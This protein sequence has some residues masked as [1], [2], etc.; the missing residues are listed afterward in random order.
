MTNLTEWSQIDKTTVKLESIISNRSITALRTMDLIFSKKNTTHES[1]QCRLCKNLFVALKTKLSELKEDGQGSTLCVVCSGLKDDND[2]KASHF[3][4]FAEITKAMVAFEKSNDKEESFAKV[5][6]IV[7][8][9]FECDS[10]KDMYVNYNKFKKQLEHE[11]SD[12]VIELEEKYRKMIDLAFDTAKK[13]GGME[14]VKLVFGTNKDEEYEVQETINMLDASALRAELE[15]YLPKISNIPTSIFSIDSE[16]LEKIKF[17]LLLLKY[18]Q[19]I[20]F[21]FIYHTF[22][23]LAVLSQGKNY[24]LDPFPPDISG[25]PVFPNEKILKTKTMD[26]KLGSIFDC[27]YVSTLRN[28]IAHAKYSVQNG[29]VSKIDNKSWKMNLQQVRDKVNLTN[30]IFSYL[31]SKI[32][33]EQA[34]FYESGMTTLP[35]GD[36]VVVEFT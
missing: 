15:Y 21:N 35:N 20:E 8:G 28:A 5:R 19:L 25:N 9:S 22:Y 6:S 16:G 34:Q 36:K 29:W 17:K 27:F 26:S 2:E 31:L 24:E 23:N 1:F 10:V 4:Q 33:D 30:Q 14:F 12:I 32:V 13:N 7:A 11:N 3:K 18:G